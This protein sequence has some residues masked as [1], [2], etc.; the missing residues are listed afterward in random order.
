MTLM[1]PSQGTE[2]ERLWALL[3][4]LSA[5]L[6]H[7]RQQT[8]ELHR[9]A[10]ELKAQAVHTQTGYTLRRFNLDVSQE[11]FESEL[12]KL[13]VSLVMENQAL[14]QEN[15]QL[16]S[17]LKDYESTLEAVMGK[18]RAHA[19]ATQQHHLDLTRHYESLLLNM[20]VSIPPPA[21]MP[22]D[23]KNAEAPPIDPLHLQLSLSHLASLVRKALRAL[24]GED[25]DDSTSP[26]LLPMGIGQAAEALSKAFPGPGS[27]GD[28]DAQLGGPPSPTSSIAS[29]SSLASSALHAPPSAFGGESGAAEGAPT[30]SSAD[31]DRLLASHH[32]ST[33]RSRILE[34]EGGYISR[35]A[36]SDPHY[37]PTTSTSSLVA[38]PPLPGQP[39]VVRDEMALRGLG[40]LDEPLQREIELEALR[41]ENDELKRLLGIADEVEHEARAREERDRAADADRRQRRRD[42]DAADAAAGA[43][44]SAVDEVEERLR[45][46]ELERER[47]REALAEELLRAAEREDEEKAAK[48]QRAAAAAEGKGGATAA[49]TAAA[50]VE[51]DSATVASTSA[52]DDEELQI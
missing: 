24:Q 23:P 34:S 13:N 43:G 9:R 45:R 21:D 36:T 3:S 25:P 16:S 1:D 7:N 48:E 20:P 17:L 19:H 18:F 33:A 46:E 28:H 6:S 41:K 5:Q 22:Q 47:Q 11:E 52:V 51:V 37:V 44:P 12:E 38:S 32:P 40:P 14:Q 30:S 2:M 35:T 10:E 8:E 49:T 26:L 15:R 29:F 31:L 4:E 39:A 50:P 42:R 27:A